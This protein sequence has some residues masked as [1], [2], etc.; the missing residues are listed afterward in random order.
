MTAPRPPAVPAWLQAGDV[1]TWLQLT[2]NTGQSELLAMCAAAVEPQV[3]A[4]RPDRWV[5]AEP[6][7]PATE[8]VRTYVP[9]A[10]VYQAG[11]M[12]AAKLYRRRNSP[13]GIEAFADS[14][15]Y[16]S[17]Y[18]PEVERFLRSQNWRRPA[19]L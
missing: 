11:I 12:L 5:V 19:W 4:Y 10:E 1:A 18:D 2:P 17:R 9:D 3:Q 7:P 13:A 8:L 15:A 14:V 6:V 16:V